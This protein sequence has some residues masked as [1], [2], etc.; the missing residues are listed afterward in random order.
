[1]CHEH[2]KPSC[3]GIHNAH[4]SQ[5]KLQTGFVF[6]VPGAKEV[7]A[8]CPVAGVTGDNMSLA[9]AHLHQRA[10]A[11]FP[12]WDRYDY[13]ITNA[14]SKPIAK[15][16]GDLNSEAQNSLIKDSENAQR[17][18]C[19]LDGCSLVILCGKKAQ[20]LREE[21]AAESRRVICMSH[22]SNQALSRKYPSE[23]MHT[24]SSARER[25]KLRAKL[26]ADELLDKLQQLR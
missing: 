2:K 15:S 10:E 17:V 14:Y 4:F 25:R 19:E 23:S 8:S 11:Q 20:L 24:T 16:M 18:L 1:M 26:W 6:S 5:G 21:I 13:R 22:L 7:E 3:Q 12:S 9:L